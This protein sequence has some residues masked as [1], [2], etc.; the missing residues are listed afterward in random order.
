MKITLGEGYT[1]RTDTTTLGYAGET[2][3]RKI[4]VENYLCN[5]ADLY[6]IRFKYPDGVI[7]D[8]AIPDSGVY[9]I[10]GS[11]LRC[12]GTVR[13]Q[14][15]ACKLD[16]DNYEYVKKSNILNLSINNA[17]GDDV[18]AIPTYEQ[19]ADMLEKVLSAVEGTNIKFATDEEVKEMLDEVFG[20]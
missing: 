8:V 12:V 3:A 20:E 18:A 16:G 13:T 9:T 15:L 1:A 19:S 10:D 7:Y 4:V 11:V 6:K 14:V 2:N 17:L 5:G